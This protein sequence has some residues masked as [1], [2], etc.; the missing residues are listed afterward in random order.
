MSMHQKSDTKIRSLWSDKAIKDTVQ[1]DD[2]VDHL[3]NQFEEIS[4]AA[5]LADF[6]D[7]LRLSQQTIGFWQ[8]NVT[9]IWNSHCETLYNL[10]CIDGKGQRHG[11]CYF[12][13]VFIRQIEYKNRGECGKWQR[14]IGG[15][16]RCEIIICVCDIRL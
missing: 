13:D 1:I 15:R 9:Y 6:D 7:Y 4:D 3:M 16:Y 5:Y 14:I 11:I 12:A 8:C 10:E 2:N